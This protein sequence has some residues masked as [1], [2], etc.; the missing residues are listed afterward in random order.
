[1]REEK[2]PAVKRLKKAVKPAKSKDNIFHTKQVADRQEAI[3][4]KLKLLRGSIF[5]KPII[6]FD[7]G[8]VRDV[9]VPYCYLEYDFH[10]ERSVMFKK[11]GLV[12]EGKVAVV[13]DVNEMHP[14][15]YDIYKSGELPLIKGV[16]ETGN[17]EII[18]TENS[19]HDMDEKSQEYIQFKIMRK[20]YGRNGKLDMAKCRF[21]YRPAVELEIIYKGENS[22]MRYAYLDEFAVESEHVLGLKYRVEN[23]F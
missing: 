5:G 12:K 4:S 18:K 7:I 10:V 13:L 1:M 22:N 20:F 16:P 19:F 3:D 15:Q 23:N 11:K 2:R 9:W 21:F 8:A 6:K 14:F 17:R